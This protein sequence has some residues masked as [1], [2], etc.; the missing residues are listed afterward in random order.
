MSKT[1]IVWYNI[2]IQKYRMDQLLRWY[3]IILF[4]NKM[5]IPIVQVIVD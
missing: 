4:T 1:T 3:I 2:I 5:E